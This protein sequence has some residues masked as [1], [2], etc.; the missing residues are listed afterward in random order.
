[1]NP[2]NESPP[3]SKL[4]RLDTF[5]LGRRP[6]LEETFLQ[7]QLNLIKTEF[8]IFSASSQTAKISEKVPQRNF[9]LQRFI[10]QIV[11]HRRKMTV[12]RYFIG[13]ELWKFSRGEIQ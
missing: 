3:V 7:M 6:T 10:F 5:A 11:V 9:G 2:G 1:M 13:R 12:W 4:P 8:N